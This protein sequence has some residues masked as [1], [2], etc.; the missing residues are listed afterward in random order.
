M[1]SYLYQILKKACGVFFNILNFFLLGN[2]PPFACVCVVVEEDGRYLVVERPGGEIVFPAGF[3]RWRERPEQAAQREAREETGLELG[4]G[5]IIAHYSLPSQHND[6]MSTI[7][8]IYSAHVQ[9][10]VLQASIEGTPKWLGEEELQPGLR[11]LYANIL[12]DY[13]RYRQ[14]RTS[15]GV[16]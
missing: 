6:Q 2:L 13:Q 10:G 16:H 4:I 11:P 8:I 7:S 5:E 15:V 3:M 12:A 9:G 14:R 1:L